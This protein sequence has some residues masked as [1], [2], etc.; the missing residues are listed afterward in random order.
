MPKFLSLFLLTSNFGD[1]GIAI[2]I[3]IVRLDFNLGIVDSTC[4]PFCYD[5]G[6]QCDSEVVGRGVLSLLIVEER[7]TFKCAPVY[8]CGANSV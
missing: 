6:C 2:N 4:G 8:R 3:T 5:V 1:C 7:S